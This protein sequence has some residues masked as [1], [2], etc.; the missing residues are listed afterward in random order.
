MDQ[1]FGRSGLAGSGGDV[2]MDFWSGSFFLDFWSGSFFLDFWSGRF[3]YCITIVWV[4]EY[5]IVCVLD[6][7]W[8][9]NFSNRS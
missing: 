9:F 7:F 1:G 6:G 5:C 8:N 2:V 3:F 4:L